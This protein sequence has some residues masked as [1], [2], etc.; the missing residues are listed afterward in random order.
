MSNAA[1]LT[2]LLDDL[3]AC[4]C[5]TLEAADADTPCLCA[6]TAGAS[7][8]A[9][10]CGCKGGGGCGSSW[11][12]L[13]D[14]YASRNFPSPDNT[15]SGSCASPLA[16]VIEV[17]VLRCLPQPNPRTGAPPSQADLT[18]AALAAL[19][20]ASAIHSAIAC[21]SAVTDRRHVLGR[22]RPITSGDCGG[23]AWTVT[24]QVSPL[25]TVTPAG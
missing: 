15:V 4:L 11:V 19:S 6:L 24:V 8:T 22:Y 7:F 10:Y 12:R 23:G 17:G 3:R 1:T 18:N 13:S 9:D 25:P 14:L 2:S 21:C 20:D 16:A 5:A